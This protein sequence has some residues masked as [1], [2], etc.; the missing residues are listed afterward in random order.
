MKE[1]VTIKPS[2]L[3]RLPDVELSVK[4][5]GLYKLATKY[6]VDI[7]GY[8]VGAEKL[9]KLQTAIATFKAAT[10]AT[11]S[12]DSSVTGAVKTLKD[13]FLE[14]DDIVKEQF[15]NFVKTMKIDEPQFFAEY[16]TARKIHDVGGSQE[17]PPAPVPNTTKSAAT[18]T[19]AA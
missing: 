7:T 9:V 5:D 15:D 1:L 2:K 14:A 6:A 4:A 12:G 18:G 10:E 8:N 17:E 19:T 13:L 16:K 11:A 3:E